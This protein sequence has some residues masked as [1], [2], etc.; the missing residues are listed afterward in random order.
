MLRWLKEMK[1][2]IA[3]NLVYFGKRFWE[4]T[5]IL[6][7]KSQKVQS[8]RSSNIII[9]DKYLIISTHTV[10]LTVH[11]SDRS[12]EVTAVESVRMS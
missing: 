9:A 7:K 3:R 1:M 6:T 4:A 10:A 5:L 12:Y 2:L 11:V 8:S